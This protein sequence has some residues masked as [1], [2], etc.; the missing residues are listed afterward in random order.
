MFRVVPA[1]I[2]IGKPLPRSEA[3]SQ[4]AT[5]RAFWRRSD[6][7]RFD[8]ATGTDAAGFPILPKHEREKDDRYAR[9][10]AQSIGRKYAGPII[11]RF[12]DH[13]CRVPAK[14]PEAE[15]GSPYALILAD[16]DGAGTPLPTLMRQRLRAAQVEGCSYLLADSNV[17]GAFLT[18]AAEQAAGKR[19]ILRAVKADQVTWWRDWQGQV[20]EALILFE[21]ADGNPFAWYVTTSHIQRIALR[22]DHRT[23][24]VSGL[25]DPQPHPYQGCPLVRLA[26]VFCEDS[27]DQAIGDDSQL[28]PLA[29]SQKRIC[30]LESWLYE[31]HQ[32]GTFTTPVFLG[33]S[34]DDVNEVTVGPGM[35]L[36]IPSMSGSGTPSIA[37]LGSDVN[38][39]E[40][41]RKTMT[42]EVGEIYRVAGLSPGNPTEVGQPES[43][44]AK[45]FA[46]NE[47][48]AKLAALGDAAELAENAVVK[49]L[50][51]GFAWQ[52]PGDAKWP[53][54]FALP[55]IASE[56]ELTIRTTTSNLPGVL[57]RVQIEHYAQ[58]AFHLSIEQKAELQTQL[59]AQEAQASDDAAIL[60]MTPTI[61]GRK[62]GT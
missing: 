60:G 33:A 54:T 13:A 21:D 27:Q 35:G 51:A 47:V 24:L 5:Q 57:K 9:R 61:P 38:Q 62:A 6:V 12:N 4:Q 3:F 26:P 32:Y 45:A 28:S 39:A 14:R 31:E 11:D 49:R 10:Q 36:A 55:N 53:D 7:V 50:A 18:A 37:T 30:N 1:P 23:L 43:G 44:V 16:A 29:E 48:E 56:L 41:L 59:D 22:M 19:G 2:E 15:Q 34:K 17:A 40:S 8:Y 52:Y 20:V 58:T 46:F 25:D 42:R